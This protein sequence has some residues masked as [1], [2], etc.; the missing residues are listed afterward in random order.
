MN[1]NHILWQIR[2]SVK[3]GRFH[4]TQCGNERPLGD[5]DNL[6]SSLIANTV[7]IASKEGLSDEKNESN[8]RLLL[9]TSSKLLLQISPVKWKIPSDSL[10]NLT[11]LFSLYCNIFA[12]PP[13]DNPDVKDPIEF[14]GHIPSEVKK[15]QQRIAMKKLEEEM[16]EDQKVKNLNNPFLNPYTLLYSESPF[17]LSVRDFFLLMFT[18]TKYE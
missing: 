15:T 6:S 5:N 8:K 12:V 9:A 7:K 1:L 2:K 3:S 10:G 11:F 17:T 4:E 18:A 16:T 13:S 14:C